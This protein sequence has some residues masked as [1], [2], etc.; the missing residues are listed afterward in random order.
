MRIRTLLLAVMVA[1]LSLGGVAALLVV[2]AAQDE[3]AASETQARAQTTSHEVSGLLVLTQEYARHSESR[4]AHQW[5]Q[6]HATITTALSGDDAGA[7]LKELRSVTQALPPLFNRLQELPTDEAPFTLR[8][9]EVLIDQL[10]TST[11]AMSDLAYQWY[12]EAVLQ[13][14]AAELRFQAYALV[15]PLVML[16]LVIA[17]AAIVQRR[18]LRPLRSLTDATGAVSRGERGVRVATSSRDEFGELSRRFDQMTVA[19]AQSDAQSRR[20]E[21]RLRAVADNLPV[22]IAYVDRNQVYRF[23]NA[24]FKT[25]FGAELESFLGKTV[26]EVL[27]PRAYAQTA[28]EIDRVLRGERRSF[29]RHHQTEHGVDA[30][31]LV[32]YLPDH[33]SEGAVDGFYVLVIDITARKNAELAQARSERLLR[34]IADNLPTLISY[35]D[36]E[37][38][39]RFVNAHYTHLLG[40]E[41][42]ALLGATVEATLGP[43][44]YPLVKQ[45]LAA[46][47]AGEGQHFERVSLI[48]GRTTHLLTDYI[49]DIDDQGKVIGIFAMAVDITALKQAEL[50]HAQ[51][52]QRVRSILK[53]APDAFI[54]IDSQSRIREWNRQAEL[55]FGWSKDEVLGRQLAE[56]LIPPEHRHGHNAGMKRFVETGEGPVVNQR[57]EITAMHK[58][59]HVIPIEL[60]VAA[61]NE[62]TGYAATAFLRDISERKRAEALLHDSERRLRD[63]TDNIPAMVGYFDTEQRCLYANATV[64]KIHG[65]RKEDTLLHTLRSGLGEESYAVHEPHVRRVLQGEFA[66]FEGHLNRAGRDVYFQAHLVPDKT[67]G[68]TVRGFYVMTFDVTGVRQAERQRARSEQQLRQITDNLPVLISYIDKDQRLRFANETYRTWLGADPVKLL[69]MHVRDVVGP[70]L[71]E[72]RRPNLERA[73]R[74]ERVE[75]ENEAT[76]RGVTRTTHT[77]YIPDLDPDG[78]V[79]GI[80]TLSS[81]VTALKEV[82]RKLQALAR[83]DTLTGLPNRL[84]FNEK[85]PEVLARAGRT[86][87]AL[88]LM[89]LD[90]DR[91]KAINDGLGH[92]AGDEVLKEFARRLVTSVRTTDT[93]ARLAGDEFAIILEGLH[94]H[95][96]VKAIAQK[97]V[98]QVK[99]PMQVGERELAVT[100]S[101]GIAFHDP[102]QPAT[103]SALL[104]AQADEALYAAK[105]AGRSTFRVASATTEREQQL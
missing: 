98:N 92:A 20:A 70:T 52:E 44:N 17:I 81:D 55:T 104:L 83:Y 102:S 88:A 76:A 69:G 103:T 56:I 82:E 37:E 9:K 36:P 34:M 80:Y 65:I 59:G 25:T 6:R 39:F 28:G 22:L 48:D 85:L 53:H 64:L 32:D 35:I 72:P 97:I 71:Y 91:F 38:K 3:N 84:L 18:V 100:T 67:E 5:H 14:K 49:P 31:L 10:L 61:V 94:D 77:S 46:A 89:Y 13:R 74:G 73:L 86:G 87:N 29:E 57:I 105:G 60:S 7:A 21:Q 41:R 51:S 54:S 30:H 66:R 19:L 11:Q 26:A 4:S 68:G 8:R 75:F 50:L 101:V 79:L 1:T 47:L 63:I 27:G 93:V 96:E 58:D 40:I 16:A 23:V 95:G 33:G 43:N 2:R 42:D 99:L 90:V 12:Q 78:S 45:H 62:G 24:H 15:T